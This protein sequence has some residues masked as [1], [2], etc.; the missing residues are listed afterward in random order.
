MATE[1]K[2]E[3][4]TWPRWLLSM[5]PLLLRHFSRHAQLMLRQKIKE[6]SKPWASLESVLGTG[7]PS[8]SIP[9][10][11]RTNVATWEIWVVFLM[12]MTECLTE[13]A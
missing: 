3:Q 5:S 7:T 6:E 2:L 8:H 10:L 4:W 1:I 9:I 11:G 12:A 13:T